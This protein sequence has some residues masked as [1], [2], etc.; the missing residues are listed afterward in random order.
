MTAE[1]G[2]RSTK[3]FWLARIVARITSGGMSRN[4]GLEFAHQ[5]DR[6]FD[7]ARDLFE[8]ALVLDELEPL[9]EG[10]AL[11]VGEDDRL[12]PLGVEHDLGLLQRVDIVVEAADT[13]SALAP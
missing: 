9:R 12:A 1:G 10:E 11:G 4:A 2:W 13:G 5:H 6:P 3:H 7:E 8:Q